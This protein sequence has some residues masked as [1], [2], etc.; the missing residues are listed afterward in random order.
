MLSITIWKLW[1][2]WEHETYTPLPGIQWTSC[3]PLNS[4]WPHGYN[5]YALL[6]REGQEQ[7][8]KRS[9]WGYDEVPKTLRRGLGGCPAAPLSVTSCN[10]QAAA[11]RLASTC[12]SS[13]ES[14]WWCAPQEADPGAGRSTLQHSREACPAPEINAMWTRSEC[15]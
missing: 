8:G 12:H 4:L 10:Q 13:E 11:N 15:S 1:S 14:G 7:I 9:Q 6:F 5:S 2:P 3:S